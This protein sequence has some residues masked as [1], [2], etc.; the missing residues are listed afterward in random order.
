MLSY[1]E[2]VLYFVYSDRLRSFVYIGADFVKRGLFFD[3][4]KTELKSIYNLTR[5]IFRTRMETYAGRCMPV[6]F[7]LIN[8]LICKLLDNNFISSGYIIATAFG[9]NIYF[10]I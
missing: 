2:Q 5:L 7:K 10:L 1:F 3:L 4:V 8:S 6:L 9:K